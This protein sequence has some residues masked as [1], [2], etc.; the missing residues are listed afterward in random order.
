MQGSRGGGGELVILD[1]LGV[2]CF[3]EAG[4]QTECRPDRLLLLFSLG[5][6]GVELGS[7]IQDPLPGTV[8]GSGVLLVKPWLQRRA[9]PSK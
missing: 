4:G 6:S 9:G 8:L 3:G 1:A 7:G 5:R 2:W